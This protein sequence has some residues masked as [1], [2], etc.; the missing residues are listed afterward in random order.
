MKLGFF[1]PVLLVGCASTDL[2]LQGTW[3]SNRDATVAAA[4]LQSPALTNL[5]PQR[6]EQFEDLYGHLTVT[7][8]N[9]M[10]TQVFKG[11]SETW[12]Y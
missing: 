4:F 5:P 8:C 10:A 2:R 12:R 9:G 1:V 6:I 7:Y 3:R 11:K